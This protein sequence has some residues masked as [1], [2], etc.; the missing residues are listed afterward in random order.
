MLGDGRDGF[1]F[2]SLRPCDCE[3]RLNGWEERGYGPTWYPNATMDPQNAG[4][5]E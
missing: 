4:P 1:T 5:A 2:T 3:D